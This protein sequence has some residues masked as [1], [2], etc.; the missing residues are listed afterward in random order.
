MRFI[1]AMSEWSGSTMAWL[2]LSTVF[3]VFYEVVGRY[4]FNSPTM[5][6]FETSLY[7]SA[8]AIIVA[9]AYCTKHR[10]HIAITALHEMLSPKAR[11]RLDIFNM[12]FAAVICAI[13]AFATAEWGWKALI[14]WQR[15]G[16]A[17]NPPFPGLVK[18]LIPMTFFLM[19]LQNLV[20]IRRV[21][22]NTET[23]TPDAAQGE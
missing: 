19:S 3:A 20:N 17:W 4:F 14:G 15:T 18:S 6:G 13:M 7:G 9:G 11:K 8:A 5:W 23:A 1:D 22:T 2:F 12:F 10:T 16:S 21:I